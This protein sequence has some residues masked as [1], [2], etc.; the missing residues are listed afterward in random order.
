[1][2]TCLGCLALW[3]MVGLVGL[4]FH[5]VLTGEPEL[6]SMHMS[7]HIRGGLWK[8]G[9]CS[10][11]IFEFLSVRPRSKARIQEGRD[12]TWGGLVKDD[13]ITSPAGLF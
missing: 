13:G 11:E 3:E 4:R 9:S 10:Y 6:T 2:G 5:G 1:L 7:G 8:K 12:G